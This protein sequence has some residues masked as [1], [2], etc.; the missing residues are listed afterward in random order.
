MGGIVLYVTCE[1][2]CFKI[3]KQNS[4]LVPELQSS[5]EEADTRLLLHACHAAESVHESIIISADGT[6]VIALGASSSISAKIFLKHI[7]KNR[8]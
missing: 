7:K 5:Q 4:A 6:D 1:D 2:Q 8:I 3:T